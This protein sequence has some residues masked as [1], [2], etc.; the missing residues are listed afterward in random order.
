M[1][2]ASLSV[3]IYGIQK[4]VQETWSNTEE[5]LKIFLSEELHLYGIDIKHTHIKGVNNRNNDTQKI[6]ASK[7]SKKLNVKNTF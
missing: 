6:I 7:F 3:T 5:T 4:S 1:A 2:S